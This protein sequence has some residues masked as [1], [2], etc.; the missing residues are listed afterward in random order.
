MNHSGGKNLRLY[1]FHTKFIPCEHIQVSMKKYL[2][3]KQNGHS[4]SKFI[5]ER[6]SLENTLGDAIPDVLKDTSFREN[7]DGWLIKKLVTFHDLPYEEYKREAESM[8]Q[9]MR[10]RKLGPS[11]TKKARSK[12]STTSTLRNTRKNTTT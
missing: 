5:V 6:E 2:A 9:D 11:S 10:E 12:A 8:D 1:V 4:V 3:I 7:I